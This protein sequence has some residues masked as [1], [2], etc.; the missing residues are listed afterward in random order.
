MILWYT[1]DKPEPG[2]YA[3]GQAPLERA[4]LLAALLTPIIRGEI[5]WVSEFGAISFPVETSAQRD[6]LPRRAHGFSLQP[7]GYKPSLASPDYRP[8]GEATGNSDCHVI[9]VDA[10]PLKQ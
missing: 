4:T 2:P 8:V 9:Y 6:E 1:E 3:P 10:R 5:Q 7:S